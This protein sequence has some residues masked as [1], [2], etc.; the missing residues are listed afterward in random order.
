M[1]ET[2][3]EE[4]KQIE[5]DARMKGEHTV[6]FDEQRT[7][8]SHCERNHPRHVRSRETDCPYHPETRPLRIPLWLGCN[9]PEQVPVMAKHGTGE[10][11]REK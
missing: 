4:R 5:R 11:D 7:H 10:S 3:K 1:F 9:D 8:R 6:I 2:F